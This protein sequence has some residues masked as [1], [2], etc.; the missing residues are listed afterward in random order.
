LKAS[1]VTL[2]RVILVFVIVTLFGRGFY[3]NALASAL[4]GIIIAMDALDGYIA[5]RYGETSAQGAVFDI[6]GDRI[7]ENVLWIYFACV[8]EYSFW[9]PVIVITRDV[10]VDNLRS[11]AFAEGKTAFGETT[12]QKAEWAKLLV[13]SRLSRGLYAASKGVCFTYLGV[14]ITAESAGVSSSS[15][16]YLTLFKYILVYGTVIFCLL[17]GFPVVWEGRGYLLGSRLRPPQADS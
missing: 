2:S 3:L 11:M 17:R 13:S 6:L 12:M 1:I 10:M 15:M 16:D 4:T 14:L 8:G 5:R 7:V 9:V